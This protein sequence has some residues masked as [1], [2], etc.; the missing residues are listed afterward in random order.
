MDIFTF[1]E[2]KSSSKIKVSFGLL[3]LFFLFTSFS[4]KADTVDFSFSFYYTDTDG[5]KVPN[6][7]DIDDDGDGIIDTNEGYHATAPRDTDKDGIPD[8]LDIDS[9][10]DG[11]LDNVE[12]QTSTGYIAPSGK[13]V[14]GNGLDDAYEV[15]PGSCGGLMPIDTDNDGKPDYLDIDSDNDGILDNVESQGDSNYIHP[16]TFDNNGNGL[17]D[18]YENGSTIGITPVDTDGDTKPDFRDLD[19]DNDGILDNVEAQTTSEFKAPCGMDSDGNGLDDHYET[20]PGSGEGITPVDTDGDQT[21]DFR[22]LDSDNDSCSDTMEAGFIDAFLVENRDGR[23]GSLVP[24][25][26]NSMGKVVSGENGQ[27]YTAPLDSNSNG[28]L[29]FREASNKNACDNTIEIVDDTATTEEN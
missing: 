12:A 13:D 15:S 18:A 7:K 21:P 9:D 3:I 24:P 14:D 27:G 25:T 10:N 6:S 29:D 5:D 2:Y 1:N 11:I 17:D 28:I 23:L 19:S 22:D 16:C 20:T 8:Y 4:N 26:V